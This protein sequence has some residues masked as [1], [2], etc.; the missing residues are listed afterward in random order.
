MQTGGIKPAVA[1]RVL[2]E[3]GPFRLVD[4]GMFA[5]LLRCMA[6]AEAALIEQAPDGL[7]MI[8]KTGE[9][10]TESHEFYPVFVTEREYRII[11]ETR[12]LGTYPLDS[13]LAKGETL[14]FAGRRWKI[15][16]IDDAA[17]VITVR[18]AKFGKPPYFPGNG[19]LIHDRIVSMMRHILTATEEYPFIDRAAAEML[20]SAREAYM[21]LGL[22]RSSVVP[23]GAGVMLF[24]WV[25]TR[26]LA[27]LALAFQAREFETAHHSHVIELQECEASSVEMF[28]DGLAGGEAPDEGAMAARIAQP[29]LARFDHF[30]TP[31]LMWSVTLRERLDLDALPELARSLLGE[32]SPRGVN[33][34]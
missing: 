11:H 13:L 3:R 9:L 34:R 24:P 16:E 19:G 1:Y 7:L 18:P 32:C 5:E 10:L 20:H 4:R 14:I 21:A 17:H 28:L 33:M 25:G 26:K 22:D 6:S 2:C 31:E 15:S 23:F 12:V 30:L 29:N 8:G 27:T